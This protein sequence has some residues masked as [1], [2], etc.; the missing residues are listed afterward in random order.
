MSKEVR[1]ELMIMNSCSEHQDVATFRGY[2]TLAHE[3]VKEEKKVAREEAK[4]SGQAGGGKEGVVIVNE[5]LKPS[6]N[7]IKQLISHFPIHEKYV[8][9]LSLSFPSHSPQLKLPSH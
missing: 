1:G 9:S 5:Y 3:T 8:P 7:T 4:E 6:G 2:R